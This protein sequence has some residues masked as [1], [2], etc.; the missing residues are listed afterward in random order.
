M[1]AGPVPGPPGGGDPYPRRVL[2]PELV[3]GRI[4][5]QRRGQARFMRFS[6]VVLL[7]CGVL[8]AGI[9]VGALLTQDGQIQVTARV[10]S[11]SCHGQFDVALRREETRCDAQVQFSANTGQ[12]IRT[13]ITDALPDE[14]S[15][16]GDSRTIELRYAPGAPSQPFKQSN[17]LDAGTLIL[18]LVLGTG[19]L[20]GGG[21]CIVR[22]P[23]A[24]AR[25][26][27]RRA[28]VPPPV[29]SRA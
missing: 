16:T 17:Y 25:S 19:A 24:A 22:G 18:L 20:A 13:E 28:A 4:E 23:A 10:L 5:R 9:A 29:E 21:W 14:F 8:F 1:S 15:G 27:A 7:L 3:R 12:L 26:G 11:T 2:N 6:G